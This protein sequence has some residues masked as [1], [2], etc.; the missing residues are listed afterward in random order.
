MDEQEMDTELPLVATAK[1]KLG[2][3]LRAAQ[4]R[5]SLH[6]ALSGVTTKDLTL[7]SLRHVMPEQSDPHSSEQCLE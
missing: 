4:K 1:H 3:V 7:A 5:R 2:N 6:Y